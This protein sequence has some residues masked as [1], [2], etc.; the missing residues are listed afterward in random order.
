ME[1]E[2]LAW[3]K[4]RV[5]QLQAQEGAAHRGQRDRRLQRLVPNLVCPL[6]ILN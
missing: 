5:W 2:R 4:K 3:E 6:P 1:G